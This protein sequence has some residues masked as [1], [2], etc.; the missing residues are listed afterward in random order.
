MINCISVETCSDILKNCF[1][2]KF[3]SSLVVLRI[4]TK[5]FRIIFK[6]KNGYYIEL[7]EAHK[8]R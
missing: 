7:L 1:Y 6:I 5:L 2:L 3:I 4:M 8:I